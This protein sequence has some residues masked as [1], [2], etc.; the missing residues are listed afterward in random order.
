MQRWRYTAYSQ[1]NE[2]ARDE[3]WNSIDVDRTIV[4]LDHDEAVALG[5]PPTAHFPLD[6]GKDIYV[7]NA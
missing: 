4:A 1:P 7:V 6:S 2:T 3:A 5:L